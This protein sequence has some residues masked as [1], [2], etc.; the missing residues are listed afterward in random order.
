MRNLKLMAFAAAACALAPGAL[1]AQTG[2][3]F[4]EWQGVTAN[5]S[6]CYYPGSMGYNCFYTNPYHEAFSITSATR[7]LYYL[8]KAGVF[9][10]GGSFGPTLDI[11]CV[12]YFDESNGGTY[13]VNYTN[14]GV[15]G[16][17]V[18]TT[19]R[20]NTLTQYLEAAWLAQHIG[21]GGGQYLPNSTDAYEISGAMWQI[22]T[23]SAP[24]GL[25]SLA[26]TAGITGWV[27]LAETATNW[28]SVNRNDWVVVTDVNSVGKAIGALNSGGQEYLTHI[29]TPEPATL[30]LLGTGLMVMLLGAGAVKRMTA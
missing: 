23:G 3:G 7:P 25:G 12:D 11:F 16:G 8:P 27:N 21:S 2:K 6:A 13:A 29:V 17:L 4:G 1:R 26:N 22:M 10:N 14:L 30:L 9:G 5:A 28:Q 24:V 19:T 18:G 15:D 20:A